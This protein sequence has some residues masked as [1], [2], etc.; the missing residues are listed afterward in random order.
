MHTHEWYCISSASRFKKKKKKK[1]YSYRP[2]KFSGQ[3]GI[4][5]FYFFKPY[6][7]LLDLSKLQTLHL[8]FCTSNLQSRPICIPNLHILHKTAKIQVYNEVWIFGKLWGEI[9]ILLKFWKWHLWEHTGTQFSSHYIF[10]RLFLQ[11]TQT[12][13]NMSFSFFKTYTM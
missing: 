10:Q 12:F 2:S 9:H 4:Q 5:T 13:K 11:S 6:L 3:K 7:K 8:F 1:T